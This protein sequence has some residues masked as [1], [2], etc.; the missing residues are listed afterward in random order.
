VKK[1]LIIMPSMFIGG[2]ERSLLGLLENLD[3]RELSVD[4][5]L[6]RHE[7]ELLK[8]IPKQINVLPEICDYRTFDTPIKS[9]LFSRQFRFGLARIA[10]KIA[11]HLHCLITGE[12]SGVWMSMQ[13]TA[14]FLQP[15]LP[16]IEGS[17]DIGIMYLGI[18]CILRRAAATDAESSGRPADLNGHPQNLIPCA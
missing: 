17:Y 14:R 5:F 8:Y 10:S 4:L 11:L 9:L 3:Y 2:A 18:A 6:Y 1:V 16:N 13:Y 15:F 7:G 12:K